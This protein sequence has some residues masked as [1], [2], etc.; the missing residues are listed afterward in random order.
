MVDAG[1]GFEPDF[2][3]RQDPA[4]RAG[5]I[6]AGLVHSDDGRGFG[7]AIAFEQLDVETTLHQ[8]PR[9]VTNA[10][11]AADREAQLAQLVA[12][13][14]TDVLVEEGVRGEEDGCAGLLDAIGN[15][16]RL[17]R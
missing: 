3:A 9:L 11:G 12:C 8:L 5:A 15:D 1:N 2:H 14:G 13:A 16:L 4:D 7:R 6:I 17:E 10:L